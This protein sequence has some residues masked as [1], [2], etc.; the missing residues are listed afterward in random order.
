MRIIMMMLPL[1]E[2]IVDD[3][4]EGS[5]KDDYG[6]TERTVTRI[7]PKQELPN[8]RAP[9]VI[10]QNYSSTDGKSEFL[11]KRTVNQFDSQGNIVS[12][13]IY[14]A[15][16]THC[17]T[18]TKGYAHGLLVLETD[19]LGNKTHYS[20]DA[21]QNLTLETHSDKGIS[22]EYGYDLRN[23]LFYTLEKDK[24]GNRFE[25]Q[26]TLDPSM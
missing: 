7:C 11:L 13:A 10:E 16:D 24:A 22:I 14:D 3:G 1:I 2:V 4:K 25:T 5:L 6:V 21:N 20:Y 15:N 19:P 26:A 8:V 12:Q 23:R 18:L 9:E 17:Y